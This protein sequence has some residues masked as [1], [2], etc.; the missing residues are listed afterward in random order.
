MK[1]LVLLLTILWAGW[2][3]LMAALALVAH[4]EDAYRAFTEID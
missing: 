3:L 4:D 1:L 2:R